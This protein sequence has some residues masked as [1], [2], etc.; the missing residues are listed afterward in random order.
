[1]EIDNLGHIERVEIKGKPLE[2][3]VASIVKRH[4]G[5]L[6]QVIHK[7]RAHIILLILFRF[8]WDDRAGRLWRPSAFCP[9]PVTP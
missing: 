9:L 6:E 2:E 1:M 8:Q 5:D 4:T 3:A 7:I